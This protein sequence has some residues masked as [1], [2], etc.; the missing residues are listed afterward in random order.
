MF[1]SLSLENFLDKNRITSETW[2]KANIAWPLFQ[3]IAADHEAESV[4]LENTAELFAKVIQKFVGVHSV[5]W[6][7]KDSE[8][9]IEKIIRKRAEGKEKYLDI[10]QENYFE[11]VTD[12]V[13]IRALHLFTENCFEIDS[14]IK[15]VWKPIETA[16]AY[17]REG[18][19][20]NLKNRFKAEGFEVKNHPAGYRSVHYVIKSVPLN[21]SVV[22][23]IQ[24]RTIFEEGWSEIDHKV[25]YPNFTDNE[26]VGYFLEI[27]NR[28]AGSADDMGGFVLG[29][30]ANID[31][32]ERK[33]ID[34]K[35]DKDAIFQEMEQA[36]SQLE[37]VKQQDTTSRESV[38]RL[39]LEVAKLKEVNHANRSIT[40]GQ[41]NH[42]LLSAVT[43]QA[44]GNPGFS[45]AEQA[46]RSLGVLMSSVAMQHHH[47]F[48]NALRSQVV[49]PASA[50]KA[51][52]AEKK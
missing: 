21:R 20:E 30:V 3:A 35:N 14:S 9:L 46:S 22:A 47:N 45:A 29:L 31:Q 4:N 40:P 16:I 17:I 48:F 34:A 42:R 28:M 15:A 36:L 50:S 38:A 43:D 39:K 25:R 6:R 32:L 13:G 19:S 24:V 44:A 33:V 7:V 27:F 26:L 51:D 8:H 37:S 41:E 10:N 49:P 1:K 12:L 23:E 5:R 18:D 2:E 52:P 11:C